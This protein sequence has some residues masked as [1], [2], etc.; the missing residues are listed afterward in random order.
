MVFALQQKNQSEFWVTGFVSVIFFFIIPK[1]KPVFWQ[2][3]VYKTEGRSCLKKA[4]IYIVKI[5][6]H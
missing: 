4:S 3:V 6:T 2:L 5:Q 1:R